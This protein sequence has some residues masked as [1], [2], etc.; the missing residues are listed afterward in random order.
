MYI[1]IIDVYVY[2]FF[3]FTILY[4]EHYDNVSIGM[5]ILISE[6]ARGM[7]IQKRGGS[8]W[9]IVSDVIMSL[10]L[11][12][13]E[14]W[15]QCPDI[16]RKNWRKVVELPYIPLFTVIPGG[17]ETRAPLDSQSPV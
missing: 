7:S 4:S 9:R 2:I 14:R 11:G 8:E 3:R 17:T 10:S 12:H 16:L 13:F 15:P 5:T 6:L 1:H